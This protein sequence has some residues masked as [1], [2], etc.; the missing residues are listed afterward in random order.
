MG[1]FVKGKKMCDCG[2]NYAQWVYMPGY[3]DKSN[4][5]ICDDCISSSE[6]IGCSCNWRYGKEQEGL[7]TDEPEGVEGKDWRWIE[8][9]HRVLGYR[10]S[11]VLSKDLRRHN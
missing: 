5:Y 1:I 3:A 7:P 9:C 11:T 6:D 4:P 8:K 2:V 10:S